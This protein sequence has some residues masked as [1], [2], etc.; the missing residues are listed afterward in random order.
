MKFKLKKSEHLSKFQLVNKIDKLKLSIHENKSINGDSL[1][2]CSIEDKLFLHTSNGI[3]SALIY[4]C[5][6]PED[7]IDFGIDSQLFTNAFGNFPTDE[8]QFA[9]LV[10]E[11]QLVFGNKKTRVAL[12]T[13]LASKMNDKISSEYYFD[14]DLE[15]TDL[16]TTEFLSAFKF[17]TF[18]CAPDIEEYP[19]TSIMF[20]IN[21][22]KFSA[23]SSDKHRLSLYGAKYTGETSYLISKIQ[24]ELLVNFINKEDQYQYC[25]YKN[26]FILKWCDNFF[27]TSLES[28]TYQ[29]VFNSFIKVLEESKDIT[30]FVIDKNEIIKSV[31]FISSIS[32]S[33]KFN[34]K[35]NKDQLVISS[36]SNEK[37]AVADKITLS[38]EIES[39]D[40][41]YLVSHFVK[42][43]ELIQHDEITLAFNDYNG[44]TICIIKDNLFNHIMFPM[45]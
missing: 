2:F 3:S 21:N 8:V 25:I 38:E 33:H 40:V 45:E 16:N 42:V 13:S 35:S 30:H 22:D 44:Y 5:E 9:F 10:E 14:K 11:N 7:F 12:K 29:S 27:V 15:F 4:L 31:K 20:F 19:Y 36:S 43:L 26:K 24:A 32:N 23:Q 39:L 41:C 28:N 34:L 1:V 18:S 37:G 17:T 6:T